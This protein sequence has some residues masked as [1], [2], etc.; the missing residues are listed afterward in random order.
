MGVRRLVAL[1]AVV[2]LGTGCSSAATET[3]DGSVRDLE[4]A[5]QLAASSTYVVKGRVTGVE[6]GAVV[7]YQDGTG[8]VITPRIL[9]FEVDEY[10]FTRD[11][12]SDTPATLEVQD[13]HW[14]DGHL[15]DREGGNW[16][17]PGDTAVFFLSRDRDRLDGSI[18]STYSPLGSEGRVLL[19]SDSAAYDASEGSV[20]APLGQNASPEALEQAITEAIDQAT[21]GVARPVTKTF[22]YP[23]DPDDENSQPICETE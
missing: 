6:K 2:A 5:G 18:Q 9:V 10:L 22:C 20:W 23:T 12:G 7:D 14:E 16:A 4:T 17:Q 11:P 1:V 21:S 15:S 3:E 8:D 13:G 19:G